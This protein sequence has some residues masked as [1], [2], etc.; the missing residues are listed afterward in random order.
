MRQLGEEQPRE[1]AGIVQTQPELPPRPA[2]SHR[3]LGQPR[4][5]PR[6]S[7]NAPRYSVPLSLPTC[8]PFLSSS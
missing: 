8:C 7:L 5:T 6:R 1:G 3:R 2:P 4:R